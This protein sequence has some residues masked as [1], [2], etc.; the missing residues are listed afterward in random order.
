VLG[1][2]K[3]PVLRPVSLSLSGAKQTALT[4][5]LTREIG[6]LIRVRRRGE[7]GTP[8]DRVT[9]ILGWSKHLGPE[10][11]I[12]CTYDLARGFN[13]A[14]GVWRLGITGF[15]ELGETTVLA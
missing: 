13:A 5:V 6:D 7:G 4:Q 12:T 11:H 9:H 8:I 10:R 15:T 14:D 2:F 1:E 3:D